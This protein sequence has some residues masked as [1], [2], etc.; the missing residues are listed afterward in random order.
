LLSENY[1]FTLKCLE[2]H[3][4]NTL[5]LI[6]NRNQQ[7]FRVSFISFASG[8]TLL[9]INQVTAL[10]FLQ[11][12]SILNFQA[13]KLSSSSFEI[14]PSAKESQQQHLLPSLHRFKVRGE[15]H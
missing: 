7:T 5:Y 6:N 2:T 13:K 1:A 14:D 9:Q 4:N 11:T 8:N 12:G 3:P 10:L 15:F